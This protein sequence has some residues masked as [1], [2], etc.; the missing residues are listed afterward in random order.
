VKMTYLQPSNRKTLH[1]RRRT[2]IALT[3][4]TFLF[5]IFAFYPQALVHTLTIVVSPFWS[6]E[7]LGSGVL[8]RSFSMLRSKSSLITEINELKVENAELQSLKAAFSLLEE[9]YAHIEGLK[10]SNDSFINA[11]VL[12]KPPY[13]FY[14]TVLIDKGTDQGVSV[15]NK[16]YGAGSVFVGEVVEVFPAS[17]KVVLASSPDKKT[18]VALGD[19][20]VQFEAIGQGAGNLEL[21]VPAQFEVQVGDLV[22]LPGSSVHVFGI[23]EKVKLDSSESIQHV[24]FKMPVN[25]FELD[26]L[27]VQILQ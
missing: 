2:R 4:I 8:G 7:E 14:D 15:G 25:I 26:S 20:A 6:L 13:S 17:S 18:V 22:R 12:R 19:R 9:R 11:T 3:C 24:S 27:V 16:V 5:A 10:I 1:K 23:V 21:L